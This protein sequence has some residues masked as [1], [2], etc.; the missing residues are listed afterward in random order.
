MEI[1]YIFKSGR[2]IRLAS[3]NKFPKEFFYGYFHLIKRGFKVDL[4]EESDLGIK[5]KNNLIIRIF[6]R[7]AS[8]LIGLPINHLLSFIKKKNMNLLNKADILLVTTSSIGL[9]LGLLK[10]IGI[11]K[12][13]VLFFVMGL[14]PYKKNN[15]RNIFYKFLLKD[16]HLICISKGEKKYLEKNLRQENLTYIP[17]GVDIE[18]WHPG[19]ENAYDKKYVLA[20]GNDYARDWQTLIDSW[21]FNFPTLKLVTNLPV[22]TNKKNIKI[23]RGSWEKKFLSDLDIKKLYLNCFYVII[24]LKETIQPSGQS[25]CLQAMACGKP[26]IM[27][28]IKGIWDKNLLV[29]KETL[30]LVEPNSVTALKIAIKEMNNNKILYNKLKLS[31]RKLVEYSFNNN[32]MSQHIESK[33]RKIIG[34][35]N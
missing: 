16:V 13:P 10:S 33:I 11:L 17:F 35:S 28:N 26:V 30:L 20:I 1:R 24:P 7:F 8:N 34:E 9:T 31:S 15:F 5:R 25:S 12:K 6:D 23:I 3:S 27:S 2:K 14:L 18:F 29:N 32:I 22:S 21:D 19:E 4:I